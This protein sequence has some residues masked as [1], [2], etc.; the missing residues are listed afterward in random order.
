VHKV[1]VRDFSVYPRRSNIGVSGCGK[2]LTVR[3]MSDGNNDGSML[4]WLK[5]THLP[6][7]CEAGDM[8]GLEI[9]ISKSYDRNPI[10]IE[11]IRMKNPKVNVPME[12]LLHLHKSTRKPDS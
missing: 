1:S 3:L 8:K 4:K 9:Q 5:G 2:A 6:Q 11:N 10:A 7:V 12:G